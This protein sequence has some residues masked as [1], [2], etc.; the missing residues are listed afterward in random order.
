MDPFAYKPQEYVTT[1]GPGT[2]VSLGTA[3]N[4][5]SVEAVFLRD[6]LKAL[7]SGGKKVELHAEPCAKDCATGK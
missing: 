7:A 6:G 1:A 2:M 5:H 3:D 4:Q